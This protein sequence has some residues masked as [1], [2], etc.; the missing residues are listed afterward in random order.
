[1]P[2]V[3]LR[4][5]ADVSVGIEKVVCDRLHRGLSVDKPVIVDEYPSRSRVCKLFLRHR[6]SIRLFGEYS[7]GCKNV[8]L[9][10][11]LCHDDAGTAYR[12]VLMTETRRL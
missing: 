9:G 8:D 2:Y 6:G 5:I 12:H 10:R 4:V 11:I 3:R 1:M 7:Q